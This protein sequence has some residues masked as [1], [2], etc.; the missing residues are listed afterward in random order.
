MKKLLLLSVLLAGLG[1]SVTFSS[2][3]AQED[4][5]KRTVNP[6]EDPNEA[7]DNRSSQ[8]D[9]AATGICPECIAR[10]KHTRMNDDTTFRPQGG[11]KSSGTGG[12]AKDAEGTR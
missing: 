9:V 11:G 6:G 10:M 8:A 7:K 5:S 3:W 4:D 2:A 1:S 12:S